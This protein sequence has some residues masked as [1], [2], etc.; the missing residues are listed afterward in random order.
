MLNPLGRE[1]ETE[2]LVM[3]PPELE[4]VI[5]VIAVP[6]MKLVVETEAVKPEGE[7]VPVPVEVPVD[8]PVENPEPVPVEVPVDVP[9]PV[10]VGS[11]W[12]AI[13]LPVR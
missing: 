12:F 2:Q 3:V 13:S 9:V 1:G 4:K 5:F 6:V 8:V 11:N 7:V 10:F